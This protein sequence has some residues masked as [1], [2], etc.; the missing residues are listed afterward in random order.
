MDYVVGLGANLGS[1]EN[2]LQAGL[3]L[4]AGTQSCRVVA[5]SHVFQSEPVGPP[6]PRYLNAAARVQSALDPHALLQSLLAIERT[7]G[8]ERRARWGA[9]TL[10]LDVLWAEQAV[11]TPALH[12]PHPQL[13]ARWFA[14]RPLLEVAPEL[15]GEYGA[16]A[17]ALKAD[18]A[19]GRRLHPLALAPRAQLRR[20]GDALHVRGAGLD[21]ADALAAACSA[22][23]RALWPAAT[24]A[25]ALDQLELIPVAD[26][27]APDTLLANLCARAQRGSAFARVLLDDASTPGVQA[28]VLGTHPAQH[29]ERSLEPGSVRSGED[30]GQAWV[31][32]TMRAPQATVPQ[33]SGM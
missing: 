28:R 15:A 14:L 10:D 16:A 5:S 27:D 33:R 3:E 21:H 22:L 6:Q 24:A 1:R 26:R 32:L 20:D 30:G 12:V 23:G 9:R 18:E 2:Q 25:L 17:E 7:L 13:R 31:E 8:R 11:A 19:C 29:A 4:L